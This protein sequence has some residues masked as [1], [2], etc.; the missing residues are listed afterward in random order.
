MNWE[1]V[2]TLPPGSGT[3][4]ILARLGARV[5]VLR[6]LETEPFY[7]PRPS[8][9][10]TSAPRSQVLPLLEVA[11]V[12]GLRY[13][14]YDVLQTVSL[15]EVA[16]ALLGQEEL[17]PVGLVAR[18]VA[19][20]AKAVASITP[21]RPH[22]GLSDS[23]LLVGFDGQTRV[24]DFGAPRTT[25]FLPPGSPS[26]AND[27]FGLAGVLHS[28]LTG[29][30]GHYGEAMTS[31]L[32]LPPPSLSNP[33][34][35][36]AVDT[37]VLRATARDA[38][39]RPPDAGLFAMELEA[40]MGGALFTT[41]DVA[42]LVE[43]LLGDRRERLRRI[44]SGEERPDEGKPPVPWLAG[45]AASSPLPSPG[46][47]EVMEPT[48]PGLGLEED[49][50]TQPVLFAVSP[51]ADAGRPSVGVEP[52]KV[53]PPV[54]P[55]APPV[56][57]ARSALEETP[58]QAPSLLRTARPA[59][60]LDLREEKTVVALNLLD[61]PEGPPPRVPT[62]ARGQLPP[63]KEKA[64]EDLETRPRLPPIPEKPARVRNTTDRERAEARGQARL[65]TP[66]LGLADGAAIES[67]SSR[68][69]NVR[70]ALAVVLAALAILAVGVHE[71]APEVIESLR[72]RLGANHHRVSAVDE[73][74]PQPT[75]AEDD[76]RPAKEREINVEDVEIGK[77][78]R[79]R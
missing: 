68:G 18:V 10:L 31:G 65:T 28:T 17:P 66:P 71:F 6:Q 75:S 76:A 60:D 51:D 58:L 73:P 36:P 39:D 21:A 37:L 14:V 42:A 35:P 44:L 77:S 11:V 69:D 61:A 29:F 3:R 27:V 30:S 48:P 64:A 49:I 40:A 62:A 54:A 57:P 78:K 32:M 16:E 52:A 38:S 59:R 79:P 20:A 1:L 5:G 26:F 19:D 53:A 25:R 41:A 50:P 24:V 22:G 2:S 33:G 74:T 55:V 43:R 45:P 23:S 12:A 9:P 56:K 13:A 8:G 34:V 70:V 46:A 7:P 67:P 47:L 4:T 15:R 63:P 72:V